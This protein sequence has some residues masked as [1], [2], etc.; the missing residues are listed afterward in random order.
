MSIKNIQLPRQIKTIIDEAVPSALRLFSEIQ[1]KEIGLAKIEN[2]I[3]A[4]TLPR[5]IRLKVELIIPK[6]VEEDMETAEPAELSR[7]MFQESLKN[8]QREA[9]E[10]MKLIA[11]YSL[12]AQKRLHSN[13]LLKIDKD[14]ISFC[15]RL[16]HKL[17]A[18]RGEAFTT[19]MSQYPIIPEENRNEDIIEVLRLIKAWKSAYDKGLET[20]FCKEVEQ[21]IKKEKK[22]N[23]KEA[24]VEVIMGDVNNELVSNL[25]QKEL[26]PIK[27]TLERLN[28]A[29]VEKTTSTGN[30]KYKDSHANSKVSW[31]QPVSEQVDAKD[32]KRDSGKKQN[33]NGRKQTA[34]PARRGRDR[35]QRAATPER[36]QKSSL[37]QSTSDRHHMRTRSE[38]SRSRGS[39]N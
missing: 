4:N 35:T 38:S 15:S 33:G 6:Y 22:V 32:G 19:F 24:A 17:N 3:K 29:A 21:E 10:Q 13:F 2:H 31:E 37:K 18:A 12:A 9:I 25:I 20:K 1:N 34:S 23:A 26:R 36:N 27:T 28:K 11:E 14:I 30:K 39:R 7:Q 5:S 16:L 8:F